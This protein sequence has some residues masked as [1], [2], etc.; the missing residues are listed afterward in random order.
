MKPGGDSDNSMNDE[1]HLKKR[2][3]SVGRGSTLETLN[4][5]GETNAASQ[6]GSEEEIIEAH[7]NSNK[8]SLGGGR[9]L[10]VI[11]NYFETVHVN[12]L[13]KAKCLSCGMLVSPKAGRMR[14][15]KILCTEA[16]DAK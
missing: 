14:Q 4:D 13:K 15:H 2:Q 3:E 12:N 10:D 8:S 1:G 16:M 6:S 5:E 7:K 11:W 9:N